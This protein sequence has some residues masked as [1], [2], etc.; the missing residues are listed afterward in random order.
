MNAGAALDKARVVHQFLMQGDV[1]LDSP[2]LISDSAMRMRRI[3]CSR[4][5]P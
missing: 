5:S 3:A 2:M 1:G 4:V